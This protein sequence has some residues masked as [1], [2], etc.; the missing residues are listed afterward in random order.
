MCNSDYIGMNNFFLSA[1]SKHM[2]WKLKLHVY[3]RETAATGFL[4]SKIR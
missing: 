1:N 2:V 3:K 4:S